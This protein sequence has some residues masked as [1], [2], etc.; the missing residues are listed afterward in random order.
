MA[1]YDVYTN[2]LRQSR[3]FVPFVV[4]VQSTLMDQLATRLVL[5]LS[6]VGSM[7]PHLPVNLCPVVSVEGE[8]LT[9]QP[10]LAAPVAASLLKNPVTNL[11]SRASE[12]ASA[13][14][15]VISGV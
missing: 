5:P 9:I 6:R 3:Q 8:R 13:L 12:I 1:Q 11:H 2:P 15:A 10:H 14:D 4:D 7:M